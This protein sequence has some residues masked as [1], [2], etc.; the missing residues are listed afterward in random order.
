MKQS[1]SKGKIPFTQ[2]PNSLINSKQS[3]GAIGVY[4][5]MFSK[6]Q[7]WN[8]TVKSMSKQIGSGS[9]AIT[10]AI[11]ELKANGWIY[12]EKLTSGKGIYHLHSEPK[13]GNPDLGFT[14]KGKSLPISNTDSNSNKDIN[15]HINF[16][17]FW[18]LYPRKEKKIRSKEM[19]L[20]LSRKDQEAALSYLPFAPF[21]SREKTYQPLPTTFMNNR[22]WEDGVEE[23]RRVIINDEPISIDVEF[24]VTE[25]NKSSLITKSN[26][27]ISH[28]EINKIGRHFDN[29]H[30]KKYYFN[31]PK[32]YRKKIL[33]AID[34]LNK[35]WN[36]DN[37]N[38][39]YDYLKNYIKKI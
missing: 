12:Y 37:A 22:R 36:I 25:L 38:S 35:P 19:W 23:Q 17:V 14:K 3:I 29:A 13:L 28:S 27:T 20:Q 39:I 26:L 7:G 2:I 30:F 9:T 21:L 34:K 8:F 31:S 1:I 5:F 33:E 11:K 10:S 4:C 32:G 15:G 24:V 6:P 16:N 18:E